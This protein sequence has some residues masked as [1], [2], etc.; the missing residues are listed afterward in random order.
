MG[1]QCKQDRHSSFSSR[2]HNRS[3]KEDN[4]TVIILCDKLFEGRRVSCYEALSRNTEIIWDG[5]VA[6]EKHVRRLFFWEEYAAEFKLINSQIKDRNKNMK[7]KKTC[8]WN[9]G[10]NST[11]KELGDI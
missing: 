10:E 11:I 3:H 1:H 4:Q 7:A 5:Y 6:L 2:G 9:E 8:K